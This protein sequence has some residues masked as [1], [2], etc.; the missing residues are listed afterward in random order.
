MRS[1]VR[2]SVERGRARVRSHA[3]A[4]LSLV[5]RAVSERATRR[6]AGAARIAQRQSRAIPSSRH[7]RTTSPR[8]S[9][10]SRPRATRLERAVLLRRRATGRGPLRVPRNALARRARTRGLRGLPEGPQRIQ[11][12][13]GLQ[14]IRATR[15]ACSKAGRKP[16][17]E[18]VPRRGSSATSW[19][20]RR[21][22]SRCC[23][24]SPC[25][26]RFAAT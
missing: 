17:L 2:V 14:M 21:S 6:V 24:R 20:I 15:C 22:S 9:Q 4:G 11:L 5:L 7:A 25:S 23:G 12:E 26:M 13:L 1:S 16:E 19:R 3:H 10:L 8:A 18:P